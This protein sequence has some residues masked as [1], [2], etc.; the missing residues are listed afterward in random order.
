MTDNLSTKI[1]GKKLI[2]FIGED[3]DNV[4]NK[5]KAENGLFADKIII[6]PEHFKHPQKQCQVIEDI[7]CDI[8]SFKKTTAIF[9]NS[10]YIIDHLS[11]LMK[12]YDLNANPDKFIL[13][14]R[15]AF[16]SKN[17]VMVLICE[18]GKIKQG[19]K[20]NS[21]DINWRTFSKVSEWVCNI[22][23]DMEELS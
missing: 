11:N 4:M 21:T 9:T 16:I 15:N 23:F 8:N 10:P 6:F 19:M 13:R 1:K 20:K 22:Y 2:L 3:L 17:D 14:T 12:A 7:V 5:T 18:N